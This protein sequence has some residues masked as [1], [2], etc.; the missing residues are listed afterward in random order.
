MVALHCKK[1]TVL[2]RNLPKKTLSKDLKWYVENKMEFGN[3]HSQVGKVMKIISQKVQVHHGLKLDL[4]LH[5]LQQ[6][7]L[8]S[9]KKSPKIKGRT[10]VKLFKLMVKK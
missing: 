5:H 3:N 1:E 8:S 9:K 2:K 6:I 4:D 7:S 10:K